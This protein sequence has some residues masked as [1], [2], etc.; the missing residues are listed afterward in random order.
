MLLV[1]VEISSDGTVRCTG[2]PPSLYLSPTPSSTITMADVV[3]LNLQQ[4]SF[5]VVMETGFLRLLLAHYRNQ[6]LFLFVPE[7]MLALCCHGD[8]ASSTGERGVAVAR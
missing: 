7:A 3:K 8:Q 4:C 1:A 6:L 5:D 2:H